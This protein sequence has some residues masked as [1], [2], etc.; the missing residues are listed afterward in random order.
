MQD[1]SKY[2]SICRDFPTPELPECLAKTRNGAAGCDVFTHL[3]ATCMILRQ[4]RFHFQGTPVAALLPPQSDWL[5][6]LHDIGKMTPAFQQKIHRAIGLTVDLGKPMIERD[7]GH[8]YNSGILLAS[9]GRDFANMAAAH[10]GSSFRDTSARDID[11]EELGG[12]NWTMRREELI[13]KLKQALELPACDLTHIPARIQPPMLGAVTLADWLSSGL[14]LISGAKPVPEMFKDAVEQAGFFPY[15]LKKGLRFRDVFGNKF[16]P[17]KLQRIFCKNIEPGGIYVIESEMGS[18]K[19][20]AALY[21]AYRLLERNAATGIYFAMPTQLT[22]EKIHDRLNNFLKAILAAP[23]AH[24][25]LL[26][27][28][29]AWLDW[30]FHQSSESGYEVQRDPDSWFQSKKRALLAPFGAGTIDQALMAIINVKYRSLRAFGLAGKVVIIDEVHSYDDY[31]G[32]LIRQLI[33][34][35]RC[36]GCTVLIL[37]ATLTRAARAGFALMPAAQAGYPLVTA[38]LPSVGSKTYEFKAI[39]SSEVIVDC[40]GDEPRAMRDA[41][42]KAQT[43]QQV[44]WIENTVDTA[45]HVYAAFRTAAPQIEM[46]LIHSRFP[47]GERNFKEGRWVELLGRNGGGERMKCGR[48]LVG[49]QIL[50]Q[51][52]DIDADFLVSRLAPCDMLLQRIG[53]LWRHRSLDRLRSAGAERRATIL[54]DPA[55]GDPEKLAASAAVALPYAPYVLYRTY[56]AWRG[57]HRL[58]LPDDIRPLLEEVYAERWEGGGARRLLDELA[59]NRE[60]LERCARIVQGTAIEPAKDDDAAPTR[61]GEEPQ[62]QLLLLR[63]GNGNFGLSQAVLTPFSDEPITLPKAEVTAK[64]RVAAVR[65]MMKSMIKLR[66]NIAPPYG[67]FPTDFLN[68]LIWTGDETFRPVRAAWLDDSGALLNRSM[69]PVDSKSDLRYDRELGYLAERRMDGK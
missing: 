21:A 55:F 9:L 22:S 31:T 4:L 50:E 45:Q 15:E 43:G 5:A 8:A 58:K 65:M 29:D 1:F 32:S 35:L 54:A 14:D 69:L 10:H 20:E 47:T 57:L 38:N 56:L 2:G 19:T 24:S 36:W 66:E 42:A 53:R 40:H 67:G 26:I 28:G 60:K 18:G 63:K 48:I 23:A 6:A 44:L 49:T 61:Y 34:E 64:E 13:E 30:Q 3:Y 7:S 27:H 25:A 68:G 51:S 46:G 11:N 17:N 39:S 37:S 62:V 41:L 33:E 12:K 52:I 16:E 59:R